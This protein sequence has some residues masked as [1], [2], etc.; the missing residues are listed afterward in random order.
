MLIFS[1]S[2]VQE[3]GLQSA[4][5]RDDNV[6]RYIKK[7]MALPFLPFHEIAPMFVRLSVQTQAQPLW[8][9]STTWNASGSR[10]PSLHHRT[11]ASTNNQFV[12]TTTFFKN[13]LF[14]IL[15]INDIE[16]WHNALNRRAGWQCNLPLY[17]LIELLDREAKLTALTIRLVS[18]RKL[19]RMQRKTYRHLQA[20]LFQYW[21]QYDNWQKTASQ[22]V[23][24]C[25]HLN[26]PAR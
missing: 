4:Y 14:H 26:G 18:E 16:G 8:I 1:F 25:P 19:K 9:S 17:Y 7:L 10:A 24:V 6:F 5:S 20:K 21:E 3:L 22:L 12:P 15:H 11:G 23:K 2:K 13:E